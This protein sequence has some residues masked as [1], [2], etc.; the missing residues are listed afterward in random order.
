M[1]I[2]SKDGNIYEGSYFENA[3]FNPSLSPLQTALI[4]FV[5]DNKEYHE[6][7]KVVLVEAA[8]AQVSHK[9]ATLDIL[10]SIAPDAEFERIVLEKSK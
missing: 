7:S 1:A 6:I 4:A 2:L 5:A 9:G 10:E 8:G 3:A